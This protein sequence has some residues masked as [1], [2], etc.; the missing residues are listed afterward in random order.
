MYSVS[1]AQQ[2]A[3][4][5]EEHDLAVPLHLKVEELSRSASKWTSRHIVAY[6]LLV[7]PEKG[8]LDTFK[9]DHDTKCPGC[10]ST[11]VQVQQRLDDEETRILTQDP[12]PANLFEAKESELMRLHHGPL[13][14]SLARA[15]RFKQFGERHYPSRDRKAVERP[16]FVNPTTAIVGSSSPTRPSSSEFE[17]SIDDIDEDQHDDRQNKPEEV[18]A[19]LITTFLQHCLCLCLVQDRDPLTEVRVRIERLRT[20]ACI[21]NFHATV[22]EDDGGICRMKRRNIGWSVENPYVAI[23]EAKRTFQRLHID[24]KSGEIRPIVTNETL[25]QCFGEATLR[26]LLS[27]ACLFWLTS[28][29]RCSVFLIAAASTFVRFV[30]FQFGSHYADLLDATDPEAQE[31]LIAESEKDTYAYMRSSKWFNLQTSQGRRT[32][33]CH[34]LALLRWHDEHSFGAEMAQSSTASGDSDMSMDETDG[35]S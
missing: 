10:I 12:C 13:W 8:F 7:K 22:A 1:T 28:Y 17:M 9:L 30:H 18:T 20:D 32:A 27:S 2:H 21:N 26:P 19:H 24:D 29:R 11:G 4:L 35:D 14:V 3:Q 34:V 33:L 31:A 15:I 25:A 16:D 5:S 6:R 23:I